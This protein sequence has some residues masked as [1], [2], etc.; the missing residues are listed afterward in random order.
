[1]LEG[2]RPLLS[3]TGEALL[4]SAVDIEYV[5]G[6]PV[7]NS[8]PAALSEASE[9]DLQLGSTQYGPHRGDLKLIYDEKQ[10][11]KLVS[12][13]QQKLL[14]CAMIIAAT[15]IVQSHLGHPLLLL[16]DDP[17]AELDKDAVGRLM[18]AVEGL[19]C[20]VIATTLDRD[21]VLFTTPPRV[22][23]VEHGVVQAAD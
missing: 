20:Q 7:G 23:H 17:A 19:D 3:S 18:A 13:G 6:W 14:A 2:L 11:R 5:Q 22:F 21:R 9:R 1:M 10:A 15:R 12:R 16:L 4:G 8:L